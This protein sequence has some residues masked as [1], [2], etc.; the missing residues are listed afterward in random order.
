MMTIA[1]NREHL[2][3]GSAEG[4]RWR[5]VASQVIDGAGL[6]R[7]LLVGESGALCIFGTA[8]GQIYT[9]PVIGSDDIGMFFEF[10]VTVSGT[11]NSYTLN[12][13]VSTNFFGGG[14]L[15]TSTT[16]GDEDLFPATIASDVALT[17]D[18]DVDGRLGGGFFTAT[19]I[20]ATEWA[21]GGFT[22][23]VPTALDPWS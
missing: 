9:L 3:F 19:A 7:Q 23:S 12:T 5:G 10:S 6:T 20:S 21:V 1:T 8:A 22:V 11:S 2:D 17:L 18:A 16:A 4:S 13:G 15:A 14:I